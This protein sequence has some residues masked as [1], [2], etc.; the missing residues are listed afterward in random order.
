MYPVKHAAL[1]LLISVSRVLAQIGPPD[2]RCLE[3]MPNGDV[4][5]TWT[6]ASD[7][8]NTFSHYKVYRALQK[9]GPFLA[10]TP[11]VAPVSATGMLHAA[12]G[13]SS[14]PIYYYARTFELDGDSSKT[15]DTL[16]TI[17]LNIITYQA[18]PLDIIYNN[19]SNPPRPGG[20]NTFSVTKEYPIG[21]VNN[22]SVTTS[23]TA[24]DVISGCN[25]KI[26]YRVLLKDPSGCIS[27]S[28]PIFGTYTDNKYPDITDI[29]SISVLP[30]GRTILSWQVAA[31]LDV[32]TY[33][34]IKSIPNS[35]NVIASVSG[36][37]VTSYIYQ[38]TEAL[39]RAVKLSVS[40]QDTSC[41]NLPGLFD[42]RPVTMHVNAEYD[43]CRYRTTLTWNA[44]LGMKNG[45]KEYRIYYAVSGGT[46]SLVGTTQ[47]TSF[48]HDSVEP[49]V[50]VCYFVR[51]VN[52]NETIT[53]SSN[54]TCFFTQEVGIPG[55]FYMRRAS[56]DRDQHVS[57]LIAID[58]LINFAEIDLLRSESP[59]SDFVKITGIPYEGE[60]HYSFTDVTAET[61]E[62]P[63]YYKAVLR[64]S[65]G[66]A[67]TESNLCR[68]VYL[69]A[70]NAGEDL[71]KRQLTWTPYEGFSGGVT[72]YNIY[73]IVN[74][75]P[76]PPIIATTNGN[77][78]TYTDNLEEAA[79]DG[80][81]IAYMIQAVQSPGAPYPFNDL[82]NSNIVDVY[83]EGRIYVP[84]AFAPNGLNRIWKPVT[85]FVNKNEY[86]VRVFNRWGTQ[87]FRADEDASGWD[88]T[89]CP[90][91][92]YVYLI[93]YK[94]AR[95]EYRE[96]K[97]TVVL[98][99]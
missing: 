50:N 53:A 97:G 13:A 58:T 61:G 6:P 2:I 16:Q 93:S 98:L 20:N 52:G 80:S 75:D 95:G 96:Q 19:T 17:F 21:S 8:G 44:Y 74:D 68:T 31:D 11:T 81:S 73:R 70:N 99:K 76:G 89:G 32:D 37:T 18:D 36:R 28:N 83:V 12:A 91:G 62:R 59:A 71:F 42:D 78:T 3:T 56:V 94:N 69:R 40:A 15:S 43:H 66:N 33:N 38:D 30:D 85:H 7:P 60:S 87:V 77:V 14:Q 86:N 35:N 55:F 27:K 90:E 5:F 34:I 84:N 63:Y 9:K 23:I 79:A 57:V 92:V 46:Y 82:C 47:S 51:V 65:C 48:V 49:K 25:Q 45:I 26:N 64:D 29:D 24:T 54:R 88:G 10:I 1:I 4:S 72:A 39:T 41:L 67:R 22:L